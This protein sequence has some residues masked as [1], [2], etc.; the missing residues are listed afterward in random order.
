M[1]GIGPMK[2][3]FIPKQESEFI[4]PVTAVNSKG[5]NQQKSPQDFKINKSHHIP[6][7]GNA[8]RIVFVQTGKEKSSE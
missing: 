5:S 3:G 7:E 6:V 4:S 2:L 8:K 1:K